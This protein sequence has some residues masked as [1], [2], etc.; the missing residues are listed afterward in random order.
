M[1]VALGGG[2]AFG[3][4]F[5]LGIADALA[6][7]GMPIENAP[8]T[9][10]SAGSYAAAALVTGT[11]L[12]AISEAWGY[13]GARTPSGS[14]V[15][16]IDITER[17][18]GDA[19][20]ARVTGVALRL[21]V[22]H[23]VRLDGGRHRLAD[24]V[25]ASSSPWGLAYGHVVAGRP[26][27]DAGTVSNTAA[28]L[29][30]GADRLLVLAPLALGVMGWQGAI[31]ESRLVREVALWR[32]RHRGSVKVVRPSPE[33]IAAGGRDWRQVRDMAFAEDT[34]AAAFRQGRALADR[35]APAVPALAA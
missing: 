18:F 12:G 9:G 3:I 1:A 6:E 24:V 17:I 28:D 13:V 19:R 2:G 16:G 20:D 33:V 31:W 22:P 30:P 27:Y 14:R 10:L 23:R 35:L 32:T 4:A 26:L 11:P 7:A 15:R 34:Y 21:P 5:H 25:A 29:A 8:M